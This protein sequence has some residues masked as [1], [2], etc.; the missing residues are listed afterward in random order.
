M[1]KLLFVR[2]IQ[3]LYSALLSSL[4]C[5]KVGQLWAAE[6][7]GQYEH[8]L[9]QWVPPMFCNLMPKQVLLQAL[10]LNKRTNFCHYQLLLCT[11]STWV[12]KS[13]H[14]LRKASPTKTGKEDAD[15][16]GYFWIKA[17]MRT[18]GRG[19]TVSNHPGQAASCA[20]KISI[21]I[22]ESTLS[23]SYLGAEITGTVAW[24]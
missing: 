3:Y 17:I 20:K 1:I 19:K 2:L 14:L 5:P 8:E 24:N 10:L 9:G 16:A 6:C 23:S 7:E 12:Q 11:G 15:E 13:A 18:G 22:P 21:I 4:Y